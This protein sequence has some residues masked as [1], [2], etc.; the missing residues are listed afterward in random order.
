LEAAR[1]DHFARPHG[2]GRAQRRR[3]RR[4]V[5]LILAHHG[6]APSD[7]CTEYRKRRMAMLQGY[8]LN[9]IDH[10]Q[11]ATLLLKAHS[12]P[13]ERRQTS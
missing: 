9:S 6:E 1:A 5:L 4:Y 10:D 8:D 2:A 13:Q 11:R 7:A 3:D 12:S